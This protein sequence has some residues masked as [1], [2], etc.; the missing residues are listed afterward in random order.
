VF[1]ALAVYGFIFFYYILVLRSSPVSIL[2]P[3]YTG[4]SVLFV[5]LIGRLV[6]SEPL[7]SVQ[8]LGAGFVLMGIVLM[9]S[10]R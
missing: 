9:G 4:L 1:A 5:L 3:V 2:Y 6:F 10:G 7:T 8:V